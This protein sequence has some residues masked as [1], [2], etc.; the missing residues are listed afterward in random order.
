M[1]H[2]F[3]VGDHV[4]IIND[5]RPSVVLE[6]LEKKAYLIKMPNGMVTSCNDMDLEK[7]GYDPILDVSNNPGEIRLRPDQL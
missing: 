3:A 5:S 6:L 2:N 4:Y 1:T 7:P